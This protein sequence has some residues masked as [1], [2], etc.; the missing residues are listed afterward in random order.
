[1]MMTNK[2]KRGAFLSSFLACV[3]EFGSWSWRRRWREREREKYSF[4]IT[5][6]QHNQIHVCI[7]T[8]RHR[9][10]SRLVP[11]L[12]STETDRDCERRLLNRSDY[13][14]KAQESFLGCHLK[15]LPVSIF[16][17]IWRSFKYRFPILSNRGNIFHP[18]VLVS[19]FLFEIICEPR[20]AYQTWNQ[21]TSSHRSASG[22][23]WFFDAE[24][25]VTWIC[26]LFHFKGISFH[27]KRPW[28]LASLHSGVIQLWDYRMSTM[29]DKFDEHDGQYR[30]LDI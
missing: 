17:I 12:A 4:E 3:Y 21:I 25:V 15:M 22:H 20:N 7:S 18:L 19:L 9:L 10:S 29:I 1:M 11:Q 2:W 28:V 16:Q 8:C 23:F 6:M 5:L 13:A 26:F 24:P 27:P 14:I 30:L